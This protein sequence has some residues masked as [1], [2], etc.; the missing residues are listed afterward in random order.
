MP[1]GDINEQL[2]KDKKDNLEPINNN[3]L[4]QG[5]PLN[6]KDVF[7]YEDAWK[8]KEGLSEKGRR[9]IK[10]AAALLFFVVIS[11]VIY[12]VI[13]T[14]RKNA[15]QQDRVTISFEGP[16][17]V[18]GAENV[19][20]IISVKNNN[21]TELQDI[22]VS[23]NYPDNFQ[24]NQED[25]PNIFMTNSSNSRIT[26]PRIASFGE[27]KI[28]LGG[29]FYAPQDA[30]LT[31]KAKV[32]YS[33]GSSSAKYEREGEVGIRTIS[34][35]VY[36]QVTAPVSAMDGDLI[37]YVIDY[38]NSGGE[39]FSNAQISVIY[40]TGF[41]VESTEPK[42]SEGENI[43]RVGDIQPNSKEKI[44]VKGYI[45]VTGE[46]S[47]SVQA[48]IGKINSDYKF[49]M[50][51]RS[52]KETA[53]SELPFTITQT[54][55]GANGDTVN[56]GDSLEYEINYRNNGEKVLDDV[57]VKIEFRTRILNFSR[58][59][60]NGGYYNSE[61]NSVTW[62]YSELSQLTSIPIKG[63]GSLKLTVPVLE[64]ISVKSE[65]D[66]NFTIYSIA[67]TDTPSIPDPIGLNRVINSN[68]FKLKLNTKVDFEVL[69]YRSDENI[70]NFGVFP[71]RLGQETSFVL[72]WEVA[73][74]SND[75]S[76][77]KVVS[78][79]PSGVTWT[80]RIYPSE[81]DIEYNER[82][83]EVIWNIGN[84]KAGRGLLNSKKT[85]SFQ[86][87]IIPQPNQNESSIKLLNK[88]IFSAKDAFTGQDIKIELIE[89]DT[90]LKEDKT[91]DRGNWIFNMNL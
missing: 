59:N 23:F 30:A 50:Y 72:H 60:A 37:A 45:G 6:A 75:I 86:V 44:I 61:D 74:T 84:L 85:V 2:Y 18:K 34:S 15:F 10:I 82:T 28:V 83:N 79:L 77:A 12:F 38:G 7:S 8:P 62:R 88:S 21:K 22:E 36:A 14:I 78:T 39:V 11:L 52:E 47:K 65:D 27:E 26:L 9:N 68:S 81:E 40:P 31:I 20:Y 42:P 33:P 91:I 48:L 89:K 67:K 5:K 53:I 70:E 56:A 4:D 54:V 87:R 57:I 55:T 17:E 1:L 35:P 73:N 69:G 3:P 19:K 16:S 66:K 25:N 29:K 24:L 58:L 49:T 71:M 76:D 64:S 32:S 43:W 46:K 41:T 90:A 80:G 13:S 51:N 63:E